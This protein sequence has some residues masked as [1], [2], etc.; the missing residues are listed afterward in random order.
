M[1]QDKNAMQIEKLK[2]EREQILLELEQLRETVKSEVD[3]DIGQ[4]DPKLME[5]DMAISLIRVQEHKLMAIDQALQEARRGKYGICERCG[6]PI[7]PA[8]LEAVPE[9]T[10]CITCKQFVEKYGYS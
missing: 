2:K 9:T 6:Q 4:G 5:R 7:D 10:F 1:T 8:R 3:T